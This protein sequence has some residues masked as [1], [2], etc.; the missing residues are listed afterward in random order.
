MEGETVENTKIPKEFVEKP[1]KGKGK[2]R[3]KLRMMNI[4]LS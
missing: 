4:P 2:V 3:L 1:K